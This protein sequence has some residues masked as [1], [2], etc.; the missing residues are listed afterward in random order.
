VSTTTRPDTP[1]SV[2]LASTAED[3]AAVEA[4]RE[5]HAELSGRLAAHAEHLLR[6]VAAADS[7]AFGQAR[8]AAADFCTEQLL[9]H[10][11]AEEDALYPAAAALPQTKLLVEAMIA[12]HRVLEGLVRDL[13]EATE[14]PRVAAAAHALRVLFDA[15][16]AKEN[17]L[18]LPAVAADPAVSLTGILAGMHEL[19]GEH[20]GHEPGAGEG[21]ADCGC[22]QV[23]GHP[24]HATGHAGCGCGQAEGHPAVHAAGHA[25]CGCGEA[26][27]PA[28]CDCNEVDVDMPELDVR[29]V[30]HAIRHATVIGAFDAI[31]AGGSLLLIAPHD[32]LP[33][34][35][36]LS[37]RTGGAMAVSYEQRGPEAWHLRLTRT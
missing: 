9:P 2:V 33:L 21:H 12:E 8:A 27:G 24:G 16:L 26:D 29:T 13:G 23:E 14:P 30:P 37:R 18:I 10:A 3:A 31:P 19:L 15:H 25:G 6:M 1:A 4:V 20:G 36:Q 17:D 5:H 28:G 32:P 34:L 35:R 11:A 22:R 7:A